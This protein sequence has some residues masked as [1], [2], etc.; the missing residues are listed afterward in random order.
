MHSGQ[1]M[2]IRPTDQCKT[3]T[4]KK[5]N[6]D[7]AVLEVAIAR[8]MLTGSKIVHR[9]RGNEAPGMEAGDVIFE[10]H[11]AKHEF[12]QRQG[13]DLVMKKSITLREALTG[14]RFV[15]SHLDGAELLISSSPGEVDILL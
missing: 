5:V 12:L 3:C 4:G 14:V 6:P 8:G 1:G 9:A 15:L 7:T 13:C 11:P 10:I 2:W